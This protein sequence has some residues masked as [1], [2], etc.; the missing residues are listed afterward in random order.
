MLR[1]KCLHVSLH[2]DWSSYCTFKIITAGNSYSTAS[3][4]DG[5]SSSQ[6]EE[7]TAG[8][9]YSTASFGDGI[10]SSQQEESTWINRCMDCILSTWHI[11]P[12]VIR[13]NQQTCILCNVIYILQPATIF[14]KV[15]VITIH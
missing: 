14:P 3:F 7:S 12:L 10:S 2:I 4:G 13:H 11:G 9:S 1:T 6:Q 8:N 15:S 5:I